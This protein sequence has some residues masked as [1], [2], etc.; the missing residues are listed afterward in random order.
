MQSL[1][2]DWAI[3]RVPDSQGNEGSLWPTFVILMDTRL[4]S[5]QKGE[6]VEGRRGS[7]RKVMKTVYLATSLTERES[8][9]EVLDFSP[10]VGLIYA[11]FLL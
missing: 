3:Q 11:V 1:S 4:S 5:R 8:E 6:W 9:L 7:V 2:L 10:G